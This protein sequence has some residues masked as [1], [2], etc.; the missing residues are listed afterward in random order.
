MPSFQLNSLN[1][2]D[3][4]PE[5]L[6]PRTAEEA[7]KATLHLAGWRRDIERMDVAQRLTA[8]LAA[9]RPASSALS[10]EIRRAVLGWAAASADPDDLSF[11][12]LWRQVLVLVDFKD[13]ALSLIDS[14]R[15]RS[16]DPKLTRLLD[17]IQA[18]L[19]Q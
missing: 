17:R 11:M 6:D 15:S 9:T 18:E 19:D 13:G 5:I 1:D 14:T 7:I 12:D 2:L 16:R 10:V 3:Q 8:I 4:L